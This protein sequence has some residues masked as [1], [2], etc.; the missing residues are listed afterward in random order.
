M[1]IVVEAVME[2]KMEYERATSNVLL[3]SKD[4]HTR[5]SQLEGGKKIAYSESTITPYYPA[6]A[7]GETG[8]NSEVGSADMEQTNLG[9]SVHIERAVKIDPPTKA[10][11]KPPRSSYRHV[12]TLTADPPTFPSTSNV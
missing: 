8:T 11:Q 6:S 10:W 2:R 3:A 5:R 9:V 1:L 7:G 4:V 12:R